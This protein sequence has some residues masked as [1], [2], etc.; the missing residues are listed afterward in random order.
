[1]FRTL[2]ISNEP[3]KL[4]KVGKNTFVLGLAAPIGIG[5]MACEEGRFFFGGSEEGGGAKL[6]TGGIPRFPGSGVPAA[7]EALLSGKNCLKS[8]KR[9]GAPS[10]KRVT[11]E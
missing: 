1:M 11:C 6:P 9:S 10:N 2:S 5:S 3:R 4:G 7:C 8:S